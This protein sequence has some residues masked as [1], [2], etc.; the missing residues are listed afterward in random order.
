[1]HSMSDSSLLFN[2]AIKNINKNGDKRIKKTP[3]ICG[4]SPNVETSTG[5]AESSYSGE[6]MKL[7]VYF[8]G[9]YDKIEFVFTCF[10]TSNKEKLYLCLE[11]HFR[12]KTKVVNNRVSFLSVIFQNFFIGN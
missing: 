4:K 8:G 1:M 3:N 12:V 10:S 5:R 2:Q 7:G 6:I 9:V 11:F